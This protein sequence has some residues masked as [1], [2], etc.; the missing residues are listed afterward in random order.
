MKA[1]TLI[2][3]FLT[4]ILKQSF[5]DCQACWTLKGV[6]ITLNDNSTVVGYVMWNNG[7]LAMNFPDTEKQDNFS[8]S[9]FIY[10]QKLDRK[11]VVYKNI[12]TFDNLF[13]NHPI[14]INDIDT[15]NIDNIKVIKQTKLEHDGLT[16]ASYIQIISIQLA[17]K[18]ENPPVASYKFRSKL[19]PIDT[20][21][22]SF[23]N[24]Y[25]KEKLEEISKSDYFKNLGEFEMQSVYFF[26]FHF[27]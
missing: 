2:I 21:I 7:W 5:A 20:Y 15:I 10:H 24:D 4:F 6:N 14:A 8:D 11:L 25:N 1:T 16:G 22:I 12:M 19:G 13:S 3:I 9:L 26:D 17:N 23:N 18:L 27:D